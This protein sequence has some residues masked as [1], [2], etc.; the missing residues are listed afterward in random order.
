MYEFKEMQKP[1]KVIA[2]FQDE[3]NNRICYTTTGDVF[4]IEKAVDKKARE[5]IEKK[6][7]IKNNLKDFLILRSNLRESKLKIKEFIKIRNEEIK[8]FVECTI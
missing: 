4:F 2:W 5:T 6:I 3:D 7:A 8:N 1:Q